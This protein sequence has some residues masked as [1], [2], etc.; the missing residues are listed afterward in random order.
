MLGWLNRSEGRNWKGY[1]SLS[2][3]GDRETIPYIVVHNGRFCQTCRAFCISLVPHCFSPES[4]HHKTYIKIIH[5]VVGFFYRLFLLSAQEHIGN[6]VSARWWLCSVCSLATLLSLH[7]LRPSSCR[8]PRSALLQGWHG[9]A[10][11][12]RAQDPARAERQIPIASLEHSI[13]YKIR[14]IRL[15]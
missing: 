13:K 15:D 9:N 6:T 5:F 4:D 11:V 1:Y 12:A 14:L 10:S 8:Y 7:H 2:M 3:A